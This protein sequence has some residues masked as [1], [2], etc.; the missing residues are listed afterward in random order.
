MIIRTLSRN[1][2]GASFVFT[3]FALGCSVESKPVAELKQ[4]ETE[5]AAV[6][7]CATYCLGGACVAGVCQPIEL[8]NHQNRAGFL[9]VTA[10]DVY[11]TG[12][13]DYTIYK[14]TLIPGPINTFAAGGTTSDPEG[15]AVASGYVMWAN[16]QGG[17]IVRAAP[18]SSDPP[19]P[20]ILA[21]GQ[22]NP[23]AVATDGVFV[24]WANYG[25]GTIS[26]IHIIQP[27]AGEVP[28]V[29]AQNQ[30]NPW[31]IALRGGFLYWTNNGGG[32]A[33]RRLSLANPAV[34]TTL[35]TGGTPWSLAVDDT[36]VYWADGPSV[37]K[38][39]VAGGSAVSLAVGQSNA[40]GIVLDDQHVFWSNYDGGTVMRAD[41]NGAHP[42]TVASAQR[43][44][45]SMAQDALAIY[46]V[47]N[48]ATLACSSPPCG[49]GIL[50]LAK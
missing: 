12:T 33:V 6:T 45:Y 3:A 48:Q 1:I 15:I 2:V 50:K 23:V 21:A 22:S 41:L 30:S 28:T 35:A 29:L 5:T 14:T 9:A 20:V 26:R 10:T 40:T 37:R 36:S 24:Y 32:G 7:D 34:V 39:P 44:P 16:Y 11:W 49:G 43:H 19:T 27:P 18:G 13:V 4:A 8:A 25:S 47:N 38:V 42:T 46:W 17:T 31:A